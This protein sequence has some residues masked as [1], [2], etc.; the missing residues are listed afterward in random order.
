MIIG[1]TGSTARGDD[2]YAS[3][4]DLVYEIDN[5]KE[6][7]ARNGGFG[8]FSRIAEIRSELENALN[9]KV[10]LIARNSLNEIGRKYILKDMKYVD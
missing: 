3:D 7:T 8:A 2:T 4:I 1:C 6:F 9:N 10:D 5:P